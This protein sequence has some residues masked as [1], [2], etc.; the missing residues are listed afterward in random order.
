[1]SSTESGTP[2]C[3]EALRGSVP[4]RPRVLTC[5][6]LSL[7]KFSTIPILEGAHGREADIEIVTIDPGQSVS[8]P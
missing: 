4:V 2:Q 7:E 6:K 1:M 5:G 3:V 8:D